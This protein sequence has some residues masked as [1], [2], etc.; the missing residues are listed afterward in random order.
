VAGYYGEIL[1]GMVSD[2]REAGGLPVAVMDTL[3]ADA[4]AR[5]RVARETLRFA[6][7]LAS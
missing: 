7:A 4:A 2:E 5:E 1:D 3:M 6:E